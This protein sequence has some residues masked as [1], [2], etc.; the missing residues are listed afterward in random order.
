MMRVGK[1]LP[2]IELIPGSH[3]I[4]RFVP[5]L[6]PAQA[7]REPDWI[8]GTFIRH[9][10]LAPELDP[11]DALLFDHYLMHRRRDHRACILL[12]RN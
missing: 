12:Q 4:M 10:R 11:G 7:S 1:S 6:P 5:E 3:N 2:S 8:E 9:Q